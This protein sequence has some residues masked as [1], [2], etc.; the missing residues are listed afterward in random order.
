M[1]IDAL[2]D[3][4]IDSAK[5]I[6]ILYITYLLMEMIEHHSSSNMAWVVTKL[7]KAGPLVGSLFGIIPQCGFSSAVASLYS[8]KGVTIGTLIAIFL[9]TSDEMLPILISTNA[10]AVLIL[11]ILGMKLVIGIVAGMLVD[12]IFAK[13]NRERKEDIHALC[14]RAHCSCEDGVWLSALRHTVNIILWIIAVCFLLNLAFEI[15][16]EDVLRELIGNKPV[17]GTF[18]AGVLGLVPNCST[19]V[20]LTNLYVERVIGLGV[21]MSGLCVNAGVGLFVLYRQNRPLKDNLMIT[22]ILYAI[23]VA[24][25]LIIGVFM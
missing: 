9:A 17:I 20:L 3:A 19:S 8:A 18:A 22:G 21:M 14:E 1:I 12:V 16:G 23:G 13:R 2:L 7:D 15:V 25:G 10:G 11:Q 4:L 24:A 5:M 6:P